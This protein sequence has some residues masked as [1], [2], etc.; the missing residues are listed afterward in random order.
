VAVISFALG[1]GS[2]LL[3]LL[4]AALIPTW[5]ALFISAFTGRK[6]G[7]GTRI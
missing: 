1:V 3:F 4:L 2:L 5:R 7:H 6:P